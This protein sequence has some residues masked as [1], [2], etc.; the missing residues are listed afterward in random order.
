[1]KQLNKIVASDL[2]TK[3]LAMQLRMKFTTKVGAVT[4]SKAHIKKFVRSCSINHSLHRLQH[5]PPL[6]IQ[7]HGNQ[8]NTVGSHQQQHPLH[9]PA[10]STGQ[11]ICGWHWGGGDLIA[12]ARRNKLKSNRQQ[13]FARHFRW[14][15][16]PFCWQTR[17]HGCCNLFWLGYGTSVLIWYRGIPCLFVPPFLAYIFPYAFCFR[18]ASLG[19]QT[20]AK[21]LRLQRNSR[22]TADD[23]N[24]RVF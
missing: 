4:R 9:L 24:D 17:I 12:C 1:M 18:L 23:W 6:S 3:V 20:V 16:W 22:S 15:R 2:Q 8:S 11:A 19:H 14:P 13:I 5:P 10:Q 7:G 21:N